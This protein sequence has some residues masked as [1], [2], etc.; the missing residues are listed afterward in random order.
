[1][2]LIGRPSNDRVEDFLAAQSALPFSYPEVGATRGGSPARYKVDAYRVRLGEG[3]AVFER[4]KAAL[5]TWR[6]F[7]LGWTELLPSGAPIKPGTTVAVLARHL[8]F[9][10]LNAAR[11]VYVDREE[12]RYGFAY[13]TLPEHAARGEERFG[14]VRDPS[15]GTVYYE[16]LA[17]SR[18]RHLLSY[19]GYPVTRLLQRRFASDS[20][21]A[22]VAA[23][24]H[25]RG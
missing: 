6:M 13:G 11:V 9:V 8:G 20:K 19:A 2:F 17:F 25:T 7:D 14:I 12:H 4:G 10:S 5:R 15:D 21:R 22:M 18:P 24:E 1:V 23:V 16:V 3:D